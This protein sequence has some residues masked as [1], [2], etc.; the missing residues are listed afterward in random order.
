M[1]FEGP[2]SDRT[3]IRELIDQYC[4]AVA[5]RDAD[6]WAKTWADDCVWILPSARSEGKKEVVATWLRIMEGYPFAALCAVP[7]MIVVEG[8]RARARVHVEETV[9]DKEGKMTRLWSSYDD[10]LVK[11]DGRWLF[12]RRSYSVRHHKQL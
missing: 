3:E 1:S 10:E 12:K 11:S 9:A 7:G 2:L 4:D 6:R 5:L 8:D